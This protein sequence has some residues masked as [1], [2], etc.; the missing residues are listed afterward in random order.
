[1]KGINL[2]A[3]S[4][5]LLLTGNTYRA[6][7]GALVLGAA[8]LFLCI[9]GVLFLMD[10]GRLDQ[11]EPRSRPKTTTASIA[12]LGPRE[13]YAV[14]AE[15]NIFAEK[16]EAPVIKPVKKVKEAVLPPLPPPPL[17]VP[18]LTLIGT[19]LTNGSEAALMDVGGQRS[20]NFRAGD[21]IEG[22]IVKEIRKDTVLLERDGEKLKVTMSSQTGSNARQPAAQQ[23]THE[24]NQAVDVVRKADIPQGL[25]PSTNIS[26]TN[27][28]RPVTLN[29]FKP[30]Q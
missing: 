20:G 24:N 30:R 28:S 23:T 27:G 2:A 7:N 4:R 11:R 29:P 16:R 8:A 22:F 6:V 18:R 17:P 25:L 21:I 14:I 10:G 3:V 12:A 26:Q 13:A 15:K 5:L 1:M 19:V 9:P